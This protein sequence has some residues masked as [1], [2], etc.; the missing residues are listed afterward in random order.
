MADQQ[1]PDTEKGAEDT[2]TGQYITADFILWQNLTIL[3][4]VGNKCVEIIK[5]FHS[6]T[7]RHIKIQRFEQ[8]PF[9]GN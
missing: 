1:E 6:L 3:N 5:R 8:R 2:G 9:V 7:K 4:E